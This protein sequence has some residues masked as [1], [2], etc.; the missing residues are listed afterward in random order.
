M[1]DRGVASQ[2]PV[3]EHAGRM[4]VYKRPLPAAEIGVRG[5]WE[6]AVDVIDQAG[7]VAGSAGAL[8]LAFLNRLCALVPDEEFAVVPRSVPG[9]SIDTFIKSNRNNTNYG[10]ALQRIWWAIED[11]PEPCRIAGIIWWQGEADASTANANVWAQKFSSLVSDLRVD[12]QNLDLP[13]V[14]VRLGEEA[15]SSYTYWGQMRTQQNQMTMK[16]LAMVNI[17]DLPTLSDKV[18]YA[19][20]SYLTI[21]ERMADAIAPM[22]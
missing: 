20:P 18:H 1:C 14:F 8:Q 19:T 5:T 6:P 10:M 16:N 2:L 4:F 22:L 15:I 3:F 7:A 12:L 11:S 9:V 13:V 21:G 17:D